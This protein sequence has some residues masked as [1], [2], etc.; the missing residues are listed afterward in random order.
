MKNVEVLILLLMLSP[1]PH[2]HNYSSFSGEY[3][4]CGSTQ[5]MNENK[6]PGI[7]LCKINHL[8]LKGKRLHEI[9]IQNNLL[10]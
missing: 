7:K 8:S 3:R 4:C 1:S 6:F 10:P 5:L 2:S 9:S